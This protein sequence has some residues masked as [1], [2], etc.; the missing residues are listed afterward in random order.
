MNSNEEICNKKRNFLPNLLIVGLAVIFTISLLYLTLELHKILDY[1]L[2]P[3]FQPIWHTKFFEI[4][5]LICFSV[6][7]LIVILGFVIRKL[8]ISK[9]G[10]LFLILPVFAHFL[11][12]MFLLAGI[13][14]FQIILLPFDEFILELGSIIKLPYFIISIVSENPDLSIWYVSFAIILIGLFIFTMGV[15]AWFQ[16]VIKRRKIVDF[17]IYKFSRHPQLLGYLLWSYGIYLLTLIK[18]SGFPKGAAIFDYTLMW[19][20][21]ALI[22]IGIALYE[23]ILMSHKF[24]EQYAEYQEKAS[25]LIPFPKIFKSA[26]R[27]PIRYFFKKETPESAKEEL[28]LLLFYGV[29]IILISLPFNFI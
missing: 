12:A 1:L 6:I 9:I 28:V 7:I 29:I 5:G 4:L 3:V 8:V 14:I 25:F 11:V 2:R 16:G 10:S 24:P 19:L 26:L 20:I 23:E 27:F 22:I 13:Q 18:P 17:S 21:T 15:I